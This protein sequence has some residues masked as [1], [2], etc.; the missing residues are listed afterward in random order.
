MQREV[1]DGVGKAFVRF[2][3]LTAARKF[4]AETNGRKSARGRGRHA[5]EVHKSSR[6]LEPGA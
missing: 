5:S 6:H 2:Q 1:V 3:D 4:Q